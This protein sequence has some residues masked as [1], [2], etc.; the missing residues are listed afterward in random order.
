MITTKNCL[1]IVISMA[2]IGSYQPNAIAQEF[3]RDYEYKTPIPKTGQ[4]TIRKPIQDVPT[5]ALFES[6]PPK[7]YI[8]DFA[9]STNFLVM[10][11]RDR[12]NDLRKYWIQKNKKTGSVLRLTAQDLPHS[13]PSV[14]KSGN[15]QVYLYHDGRNPELI[16]AYLE[17]YNVIT[18]KGRAEALLYY[19]SK[20]YVSK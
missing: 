17:S 6:C 16:N 4:V 19:Y 13:Q 12:T 3:K 14:W 11:C 8:Y 18:K 1:N 20:F 9:E 2:L 7:S 15:Y 10:V 5:K